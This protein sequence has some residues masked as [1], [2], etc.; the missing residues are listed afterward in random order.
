[1]DPDTAGYTVVAVY[2]SL[3]ITGVLGNTWV[4]YTVLKQLGCLCSPSSLSRHRPAIPMVQSSACIYLLL[5]SVVDL[6]SF[7]SVPLLAIDIWKNK[8]IFGEELC[9][10]L[11]ACEGANKSLSPLVLTALSIDRYIAVCRPTLL[12]MRRTKFSLFVIL[13]CVFISLF[14]IVPVIMLAHVSNMQDLR[15]NEHRKCVVQMPRAFDAVHTAACY[16]LPL[17]VICAVYVAIL[18]RLYRHT[19]LSSVGRRTSISL[20]RVVKCSVMV[21]AF[22]FICWTPYWAMRF[23]SIFQPDVMI[24]NETYEAAENTTTTN[25]T[26]NIFE[27]LEESEPESMGALTILLFY[28]L[29]ALPYAQSAFN[30]L[31]YAFLNRNLRNSSSRC[32]T[33]IRSAGVTSA[34]YENGHTT[35]AA[36]STMQLWKNIQTMGVHLKSAGK[37]TGNLILKRSPFRSHSR[38]RSRSSTCL[39]SVNERNALSQNVS[40]AARHKTSEQTHALFASMLEIFKSGPISTDLMTG[41]FALRNPSSNGSPSRNFLG[42]TAKNANYG[43][44][45]HGEPRGSRRALSLQMPPDSQGMFSEASSVEWL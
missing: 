43:L 38:I 42:I 5:L 44:I 3:M 19:R 10:L 32:A 13:I 29:H 34:M 1:M 27:T 31:F 2:S 12:W 11:Y 28:L 15:M 26:E 4:M 30:W 18:V 40:A 35:S 16:V 9:K 41:H 17:I 25:Y 23:I 21:V 14:F 37:D 33:T 20:G 22:Y 39:D 36:N 24:G 8:W 45:P 6:F 7:V